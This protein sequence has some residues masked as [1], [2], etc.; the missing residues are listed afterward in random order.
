VWSTGSPSRLFNQSL[1][2]LNHHLGHLHVTRGGSSKVELITSP[3]TERCMSGDFFGPLV[4]KQHVRFT[5]G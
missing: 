2:L 5:S 3:F 4:D 1:R